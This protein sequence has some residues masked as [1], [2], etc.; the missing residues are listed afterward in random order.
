MNNLPEEKILY[1]E[2]QKR[3][4]YLIPEKWE[5]IHLYASITDSSKKKSIGEMY[6]YYFP[7]GIIKKKPINCYEIPSIF[8]IDEDEF[9]SL[10]NKLYLTIK[11][12]RYSYYKSKKKVW[13]EINI[14]IEN[15]QFKI[16]YGFNNLAKSKRTSY[17]RHVIWRYE[18]LGLDLKNFDKNEVSI[19]KNYLSEDKSKQKKKLVYIEGLYKIPN[20]NIVDYERVLTVDEAIERAKINKKE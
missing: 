11:K 7:K 17:E 9:S 2:I 20:K 16:E 12:L 3:L 13:Y 19:I 14:T 5:S 1:S 18:N 4:I 6:F 8:N 15:F 10:I